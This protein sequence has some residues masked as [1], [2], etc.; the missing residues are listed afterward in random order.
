MFG[1]GGLLRDPTGTVEAEA[2]EMTL[3]IT[4]T[5]MAVDALATGLPGAYTQMAELYDRQRQATTAKAMAQLMLRG[6]SVKS[7][8]ELPS[9]A[10]TVAL[11]EGEA[12]FPNETAWAARVLWGEVRDERCA[13]DLFRPS[14]PF[15][16]SLCF[17][18][19][20]PSKLHRARPI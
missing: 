15:I 12:V 19:A 8:G 14:F 9:I 16:N 6:V 18:R 4:F 11:E 20:P 5:S 17:K 3:T 10:T 13:T 2:A 1:E 7:I